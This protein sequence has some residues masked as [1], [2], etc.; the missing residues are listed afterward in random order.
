[1][2][3]ALPEWLSRPAL[4]PASASPS[5][6]EAFH[7]RRRQAGA[8]LCPATLLSELPRNTQARLWTVRREVKRRRRFDK[9]RRQIRRLNHGRLQDLFPPRHRPRFRSR[10]HLPSRCRS[11]AR[12]DG[13]EDRPYWLH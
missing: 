8:Q 2:I 6:A 7:V 3:F 12:Q 13:L 9:R 1:A 10:F 4:T 5:F 11:T